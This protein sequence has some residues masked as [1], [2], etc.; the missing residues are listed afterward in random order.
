M[1]ARRRLLALIHVLAQ[2]IL[3]VDRVQAAAHGLRA[4]FG[5]W[6]AAA[7]GIVGLAKEGHGGFHVDG[8]RDDRWNAAGS[9]ANENEVAERDV[10]HAPSGRVGAITLETARAYA[11]MI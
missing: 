5:G 2:R 1:H 9:G 6:H 4:G 7:K 10:A 8:S 11:L 3:K